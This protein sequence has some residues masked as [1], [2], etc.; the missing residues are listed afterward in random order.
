MT[1]PPAHVITAPTS[2]FGLTRP[3]PPLGELERP[4]KVGAVRVCGDEAHRIPAIPAP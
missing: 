2:G 3:R 4:A 1:S